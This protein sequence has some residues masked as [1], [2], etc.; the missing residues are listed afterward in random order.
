MIP[1]NTGGWVDLKVKRFHH[2]ADVICIPQVISYISATI[3]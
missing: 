1:E 2:K 3:L